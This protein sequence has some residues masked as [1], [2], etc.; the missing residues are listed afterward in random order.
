VP[1]PP[2]RVRGKCGS[3]GLQQQPQLTLL[4][5]R[6]DSWRAGLPAPVNSSR[7][8]A[9]LRPGLAPEQ[10][11]PTGPW[12]KARYQKSDGQL[13]IHRPTNN[14]QKATRAILGV[15]LPQPVPWLGKVKGGGGGAE[16]GLSC[17]K[18]LLVEQGSL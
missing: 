17:G 16:M 15:E 9:I 18:S 6:T 13:N 4:R 10:T 5:G 1:S 11:I 2:G 8:A 3:Y 14:H 12:V 7:N